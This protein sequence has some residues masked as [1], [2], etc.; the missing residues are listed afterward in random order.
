MTTEQIG[1]LIFEPNPQYPY[2][3]PVAQPPHFW[4]TEQTGKLADAVEAYFNGERLA[5]H[6]IAVIKLYLT[7]YVERA[8]LTPDARRDLLLQQIARLRTTRE[9]ERFA[10]H[11]ADFGVEPF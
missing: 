8:M 1:D 9:I 5:S 11:V 4:M 3:F 6:Q 7:Q 10:D 2:P